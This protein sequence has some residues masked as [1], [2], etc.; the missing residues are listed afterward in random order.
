MW[1]SASPRPRAAGAEPPSL[2][3][4]PIFPSLRASDRRHWRGNPFPPS[5]RRRRGT[6]FAVASG[7]HL[8]FN[9]E[10]KVRKN[11]AKTYGFGFPRRALSC[12]EFASCSSR[13]RF[14]RVPLSV[15]RTVPPQLSATASLPLPVATVGVSPSTVVP[16]ERDE[17]RGFPRRFAPR[18]DNT[19]GLL[20]SAVANRPRCS[21]HCEPVL[22]LVWQSVP[23]SATPP[24]RHH[25]HSE[26]VLTL[27][28]ES[29]PLKPP[30]GA[31]YIVTARCAAPTF[32][33][34]LHRKRRD[35][36]IALPQER[37]SKGRGRARPFPLD[38]S[39][40]RDF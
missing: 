8:S 21:C 33:G 25:R 12:R 19:R 3:T 38:A 37:V 13:N 26:P 17:R 18:N 29:V 15:K 28:W 34:A 7:G 2:Q 40:G 4:T 32:C 36:I 22:T 23:P 6:P 30:P 20:L 35:L 16:G 5:P 9:S 31:L 10:R 24:A 1:Q 14:S 11:A 39:R 27:A